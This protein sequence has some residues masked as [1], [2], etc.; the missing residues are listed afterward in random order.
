MAGVGVEAEAS[1]PQIWVSTALEGPVGRRA[2]KFELFYLAQP[3]GGRFGVY[4]DDE[5][6]ARVSARADV[7]TASYF[8]TETEDGP[9]SFRV[10]SLGGGPVRLFGTV[11]EREGPGVVVDS[12]GING[13]RVT[14]LLA[15]DEFILCLDS[16]GYFDCPEGDEP[17]LEAAWAVCDA[18]FTACAH[19]DL[20]CAEMLA[21]METCAPTDQ[22][23][24]TS[25]L[26]HGTVEAQEKMAAVSQCLL[27]ECGEEMTEECQNTAL[28][29]VCAEVY[30]D[31]SG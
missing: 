17:C 27:D 6:V 11:L 23:C 26:V 7:P 12:M 3:G 2:S 8:A 10:E 19:G 14:A 22:V 28:T 31:C 24:G 15:W 21:C 18:E 16:N 4:L 25:C 1:G 29:G 5:L 9:H 30:A 20:S 13:A